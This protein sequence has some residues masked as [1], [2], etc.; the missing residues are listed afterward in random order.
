MLEITLLLGALALM[1]LV[2]YLVT[3]VTP[4]LVLTLGVVFLVVGLLEG[5]PTGL[6]YHV[7]LRRMVAAKGEVPQRWWLN[8]SQLHA[9]LTAKELRRVRFW[10]VLG[11]LGYLVA[12]AGGVAAIVGLLAKRG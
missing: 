2:G 1:G 9:A 6:W 5:V 12:V 3:V 8:P 7:V 4:D 11:G 10:F